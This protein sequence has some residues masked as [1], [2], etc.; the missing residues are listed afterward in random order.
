MNTD[1]LIP[2]S[3]VMKAEEPEEAM[4]KIMVK[5]MKTPRKTDLEFMSISPDLTIEAKEIDSWIV[6]ENAREKEGRGKEKEIE[7]TTKD[8]ELEVEGTIPTETATTTIMIMASTPMSAPI[9]T[10]SGAELAEPPSLLNTDPSGMRMKAPRW[11]SSTRRGSEMKE[12]ENAGKEESARTACTLLQ[13]RTL[14]KGPDRLSQSSSY[15]LT[16]IIQ[17]FQCLF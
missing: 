3:M 4:E 2:N 1:L 17:V 12:P 11:W 16:N 14:S 9:A 10:V 6:K 5:I 7:R 8:P 13:G 15:L